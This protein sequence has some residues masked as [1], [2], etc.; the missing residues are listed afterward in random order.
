MVPTESQSPVE[1]LTEE[2]VFDLLDKARAQ[3][4]Q[5]VEFTYQE[6]Y[7]ALYSQEEPKYAFA[8]NIDYPLL[9]VLI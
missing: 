9:P 3:Y 1:H 2:Q 6:S 7:A 4:E 5:Y 8:H